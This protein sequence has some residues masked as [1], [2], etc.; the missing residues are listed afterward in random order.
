MKYEL[1]QRERNLILM[2]LRRKSCEEYL[3]YEKGGERVYAVVIYL[4]IYMKFGYSLQWSFALIYFLKWNCVDSREAKGTQI[5]VLYRVSQ[6]RLKY[7]RKLFFFLTSGRKVIS[8]PRGK[9]SYNKK[10]LLVHMYVVKNTTTRVIS[11]EMRR[12]QCLQDRNTWYAVK[13]YSPSM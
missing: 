9:R 11:K 13:C 12:R 2:Y 1:S 3:C 8:P 10:K 6:R 7:F 5:W 4:G